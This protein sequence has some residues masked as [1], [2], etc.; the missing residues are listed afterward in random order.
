M[1]KQQKKVKKKKARERRVKK[2]NLARR[3]KKRQEVKYEKELDREVEA[4][5]DKPQPILNIQKK[6][7]E[8]KSQLEHNLEL[9]KALEEQYIAEEKQ[10]E[11]LNEQLEEEG[12]STLEEKMNALGAKAEA[13]AKEEGTEGILDWTN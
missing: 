3:D 7:S 10:R 1:N 12:Y 11:E 13:I 6:D 2:E 4:N 8:I 5:R 9:L